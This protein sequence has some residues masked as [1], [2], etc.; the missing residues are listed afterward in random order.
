MLS[1]QTTRRSRARI[2]HFL[3][4]VMTHVLDASESLDESAP[5]SL[6][7]ACRAAREPRIFR[8]GVEGFWWPPVAAQN[9]SADR[10]GVIWA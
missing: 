9:T 6:V 1:L 4:S 3:L 5:A 10:R 8:R 7:H 2:E